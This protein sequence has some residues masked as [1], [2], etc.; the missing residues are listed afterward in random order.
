MP[1][2]CL[3]RCMYLYMSFASMRA[4]LALYTCAEKYTNVCSY[5][6]S[7]GW[8]SRCG[9]EIRGKRALA[10]RTGLFVNFAASSSDLRVATLEICIVGRD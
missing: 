8:M 1:Q 5:F 6:A 2:K 9:V 7:E 4:G 10:G 3:Y